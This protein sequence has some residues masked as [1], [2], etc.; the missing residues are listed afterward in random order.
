MRGTDVNVVESV[1]G[2][3][4]LVRCA[5]RA[6]AIGLVTEGGEPAGDDVMFRCPD[7]ASLAAAFRMLQRHDVPFADAPHGWPPAAI[8][9][10]LRDA[11]LVEGT[12]SRVSWHGP[13][14]PVMRV[15]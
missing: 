14:R 9:D 10:E 8:F 12:I 4:V 7:R 11:G 15:G 13:G 6:L 3:V 2:G 1:Q 5:E